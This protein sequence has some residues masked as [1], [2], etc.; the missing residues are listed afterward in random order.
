MQI[1]KKF[2]HSIF[3]IKQ[4]SKLLFKFIVLLPWQSLPQSPLKYNHIVE[5]LNKV[6]DKNIY[7]L[8]ITPFEVLLPKNKRFSFLQLKV[9]GPNQSRPMQASESTSTSVIVEIT[10]MFQFESILSIFIVSRFGEYSAT[11]HRDFE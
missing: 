6:L 7:L 11:I 10:K 9:Q 3:W 4:K 8:R 2:S 5:A 1:F